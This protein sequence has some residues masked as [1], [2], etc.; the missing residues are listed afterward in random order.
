MQKFLFII[1]FSLLT[2]IFRVSA[3]DNVISF[4]GNFY[5]LSDYIWE[6]VVT[7]GGIND[8][9]GLPIPG[10]NGTIPEMV[11][12]N[13]VGYTV[14]AIGEKAF[15]GSTIE[16]L[17]IP[18]TV[19]QIGTSAFAF[20]TGLTDVTIPVGINIVGPCA[21]QDCHNLK[22]ARWDASA[23]SIPFGCFSYCYTL[24]SVYVNPKVE[25]INSKAFYSCKNLKNAPT[26]MV[27]LRTIGDEAFF[28]CEA[29]ESLT[30][31]YAVKE[32]GCNA[33]A[34]CSNIKSVHCI[35][36]TPPAVGNCSIFDTEVLHDA[37][38]YLN[39]IDAEKY[40]KATAWSQF[41]NIELLQGVEDITRQ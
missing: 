11:T 2:C 15:F 16:H 32:I 25:R 4:D 27:C 31:D 17:S 30:F 37:T 39:A 12:H 36:F 19:T 21:F 10:A 38:L 14:V 41:C 3:Q 5:K 26:D 1:S 7:N 9:T 23:K 40:R 6:A 33:F 18:A 24:D 13:G 22:T 20:C 35:S 8:E 34:C 28:L 29:L